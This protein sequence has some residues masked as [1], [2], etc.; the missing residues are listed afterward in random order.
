MNEFITNELIEATYLFCVKRISDTE[1]AKDLSQDILYEALRVIASGKEFVSFY[2]WYWK[3]ARNKYADYISS[4]QNSTLPI[5]MA[6]GMAAEHPQ[7]IENLIA[8]EDISQLNFALSRLASIYREIII[9]F[10]LKEQ[11]VRQIANELDIPEGTV[12]RRL[13]DAKKNLKERFENM[14]NIGKTAYAPADVSW[15]C[16]F[17]AMNAIFV[18][19]SSKI[20][21]QVMVICR[22]EAKTVNEIADEMGVAPLYLEDMIE[23]MISANL[24]VSP[25]KGKYIANHCIF[26]REKYVEADVYACDIFHDE[27][28]AEKIIN[29]LLS[30][31]DKITALD[32]YG[33]DFDYGYLMWI[34]Y[35][36][37]GDFFGSHGR[38]HYIGKYSIKDEAERKYRLTMQYTLPDET[39]DSSMLSRLRAVSWS[40]LHQDF[41]TSEYGKLEFVNDFETEPFP[42]DNDDET[43]WRRGR[44]KWID[45]N[46]IALLVAL[47]E[48]PD[49]KLSVHEEAMAADFLKK[50]LLKKEND[51]LIVQLPIFRREIY[52]E[53]RNL[54]SAEIKPLAEEYA[55]K[56]GAGV[57][58]ILLPYVRKDLMSNFIHWDMRMFFQQICS[59]FDYGWDKAL[60]KP[61]DYSR[62][63]AGLYIL[64]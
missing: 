30:L 55:D 32:F 33:N 64:T 60:T 47:S 10:Y 7:P 49:K 57:E 13:F 52:N 16:G 28:Y 59:L 25:A 17:S 42:D 26:P 24:L 48:D 54:V 22:S 27:G 34:L 23:K 46:N 8:T 39:F 41:T 9:R 1:A 35:V 51:R 36:I 3:M 45:G 29:I 18:M 5:E 40:N 2:S 38:D 31:K 21:P 6:G 61:E 4:K 53:I 15:F 11:T 58:K 14:N 62:S 12:K 63:A 19:D 50:G 20:C 44:D 56:V 37:A 43:D